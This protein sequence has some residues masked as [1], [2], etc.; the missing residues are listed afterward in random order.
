MKRI[1]WVLL[2]V[3]LAAQNGKPV[4]E[5][6]RRAQ[7]HRDLAIVLETHG[8]R[9]TK[10]G[11][12]RL[13][14]PAT[15]TR[16]GRA[17]SNVIVTIEF[18][19]K[20][21]VDEGANA[22]GSDGADG[23]KNNGQAAKDETDLVELLQYDMPERLLIGQGQGRSMRQIGTG[24]RMGSGA[25]AP[26]FDVYEVE[27]RVTERG[28]ARNQRKRFF[29]NSSTLRMERVETFENSVAGNSSTVTMLS[30][31]RTV[32]DFSFAGMVERYENGALTHKLVFGTPV[33]S[34]GQN[35]NV[36]KK[37]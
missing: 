23:W 8:S 11:K 32:D 25:G 2:T 4:I 36:F 5:A 27:E 31:W 18:P 20:V 26:S 13:R 12:E 17:D 30:N 22:I 3:E 9:L 19:D 29:V 14:V 33:V 7:M 6:G 1:A 35:D 21:R 28:R 37:P 16:P 10:P 34:A 15:L 24:F